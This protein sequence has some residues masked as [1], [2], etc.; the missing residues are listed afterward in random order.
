MKYRK[1]YEEF[2][3][4]HFFAGYSVLQFANNIYSAIEKTNSTTILD[5]GSGKGHQYS[6]K[7]LDLYWGVEVDCY[8]PGYKPFSDLPNK[9]Y[10][11]VICT[12]VM[13]HVPEDEVDDT[14]QHIFARAT[15]FVFFSI[16]LGT[17]N[18]KFSNGEQI[19]VTLK[20]AEWWRSVIDRYNTKDVP[21][22]IM[23]SS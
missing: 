11:G 20:S 8:D 12:E 4:G 22:Y 16:S 15:K 13:E 23:F 5:Y 19:H 9:T 3:K 17:A 21:V 6:K 14:I 1:E 7:K 2:H 18:K 10:D